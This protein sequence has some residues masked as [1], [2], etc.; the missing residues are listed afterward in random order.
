MKLQGYWLQLSGKSVAHQYDIGVIPLDRE[1]NLDVTIE[2][3]V[4]GI[5]FNGEQV[6]MGDGSM[7]ATR[8]HLP[9]NSWLAGGADFK[10]ELEAALEIWAEHIGAELHRHPD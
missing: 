7:R 9:K 4:Y 1:R 2:F 10:S 5:A 8:I 6:W 3:A